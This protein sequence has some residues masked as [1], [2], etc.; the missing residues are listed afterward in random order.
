MYGRLSGEDLVDVSE[1]V[2]CFVIRDGGN[3]VEVESLVVNKSRDS[4]TQI[5]TVLPKLFAENS[6][7]ILNP[8][9]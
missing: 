1:D 2:V 4:N 6:N 8:G 5:E 9:S 7:N 3:S